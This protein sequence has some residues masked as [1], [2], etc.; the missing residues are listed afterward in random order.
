MPLEF[1]LCRSGILRF[2]I[3]LDADDARIGKTA[4]KNERAFPAGATGFENL[5]RRERFHR[6]V[7]QKHFA[8]PDSAKTSFGRNASYYVSIFRQQNIGAFR[9]GALGE[10][11]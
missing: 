8:L 9:D 2:S 7:K 5:F 4:R 6:R 10:G 3:E 1:R 11:N